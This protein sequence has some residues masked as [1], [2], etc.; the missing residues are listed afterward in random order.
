M[1]T[2]RN[3]FED[4]RNPNAPWITQTSITGSD[5]LPV[6]IIE[7]CPPGSYPD[8]PL[9]DYMLYMVAK[10][11][12]N[13][14]LDLGAGLFNDGQSRP[15]SHNV[16]A[17]NQRCD[18]QIDFSFSLYGI[19]L[20]KRLLERAGERLFGQDAPVIDRL[21]KETMRDPLLGQMIKALVMEATDGNPNGA[22][23]ADYLSNAA[24]ARLYVLERAERPASR[25]VAPF[26]DDEAS[27]ILQAME[28]QM[29][30]RVTLD[31][32]SALVGMDI[33]RFSRA[34]RARFGE[35][36]YRFMLLRRV[37]RAEALLRDSDMSIADIAFAC[38][39]SSQAH[40]TATFSKLSHATPGAIR[41]A[42]MQ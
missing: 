30:E 5:R 38:G 9:D 17:P 28:D 32:L 15:G 23:Y 41:R 12:G 37:K 8:P 35:T 18:Y 16:A 10:G 42:R 22:L 1:T 34:F 36:P 4:E 20:P 24:I 31:D 11:A 13:A 19:A 29:E 21:H 33:Y 7:N 39:F 26:S 2:A 25:Y 14:K 27:L 3:Y 6:V 40:L